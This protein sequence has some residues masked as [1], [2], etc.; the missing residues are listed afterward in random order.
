MQL[1]HG[2]GQHS[3]VISPRFF[4]SLLFIETL[5]ISSGKQLRHS[6]ILYTDPGDAA[7]LGKS[8]EELILNIR[9]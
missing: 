2:H 8:H 6:A 1:T 5:I 3:I 9:K 7:M 4:E